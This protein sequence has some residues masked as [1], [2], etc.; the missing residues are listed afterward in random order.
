MNSEEAQ[1]DLRRMLPPGSTVQ[2][3]LRH[4]S[5]SGMTRAISPVVD[6]ED[7]TW[8]VCKAFPF[9]KRDNRHGGIRVGGCGMDMGFWL[10]YELSHALYPGGFECIGENLE[11]CATCGGS[12]SRATAKTAKGSALERHERSGTPCDACGGDG[13]TGRYVGFGH[14]PSNDHSNGDRDYSPHHHSSGGYALSQRW[15]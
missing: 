12:G 5:R 1:A 6:G 8:L 14:C 2:T 11:P 13:W 3:I 10:V 9:F 15:L 4:V 7:A